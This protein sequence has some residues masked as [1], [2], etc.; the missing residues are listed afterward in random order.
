MDENSDHKWKKRGQVADPQECRDLSLDRR[1]EDLALSG[2]TTHPVEA[3]GESHVRGDTSFLGEKLNTDLR[4]G[5]LQADFATM[6]RKGDSE[7]RKLQEEEPLL[8]LEGTELEGC[9]ARKTQ[10]WNLLQEES[11]NGTIDKTF[12]AAPSVGNGIAAAKQRHF[13]IDGGVGEPTEKGMRSINYAA[14]K[15]VSFL[16]QG[17]CDDGHIAQ[18]FDEMSTKP[19]IFKSGKWSK[20]RFLTGLKSLPLMFYPKGLS[21]SN[22][23]RCLGSVS[24]GGSSAPVMR[25]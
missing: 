4:G 21:T 2:Y 3:V 1:G 8:C 25:A 11:S 16:Q 18:L 10:A 19:E 14:S 20:E 22:P 23:M 9:R 6:D 7:I 13:K 17:A 15:V 5:E 24:R 12:I